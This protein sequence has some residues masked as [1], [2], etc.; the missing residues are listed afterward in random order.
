MNYKIVMDSTTYL[1]DEE[2]KEYGIRTAS[3][4]VMDGG[5]TYKELEINNDLVYGKLKEGHRLTTSQPSPAEFLE[6]YEQCIAEGADRIFVVTIAQPLSGTY[7][8]AALAQ[9]M[10]D[11]PEIV[12][13]FQSELACIGNELLVLELGKMIKEGKTEEEIIKR[14]N[15]LIS[16]G[17]I[18]FTIEN[19]IHLMRSGRLSRTKALIGSV[20]RV[21]PLLETVKGKLELFGS[22][23]THRKVVDTM[24]A[25]MKE[26]TEGA[27]EI[28]VRIVSKQSLE[29]AR[30]LEQEIRNTFKNVKLTFTE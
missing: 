14:I 3:L 23:R 11:N 22:V 8:S 24:L 15:H 28:Y 13:L 29:N 6:L 27:K 10:L 7:Q 12:H 30:A 20:L 9:K 18:N 16:R 2:L 4:N 5:E 25:K 21:K 17:H 19:L 1:S 26:T